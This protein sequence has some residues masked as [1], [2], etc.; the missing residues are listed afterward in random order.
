[1]LSEKHPPN[2]AILDFERRLSTMRLFER[3]ADGE[4]DHVKILATAMYV[5]GI[6]YYLLHLFR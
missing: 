2:H 1:V 3:Y 5:L 4:R 6:A